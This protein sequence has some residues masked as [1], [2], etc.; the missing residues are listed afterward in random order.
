MSNFDK[1]K[2]RLADILDSPAPSP[3][4]KARIKDARRVRRIE[5]KVREATEA[6]KDVRSEAHAAQLARDQA[7][8]AASVDAVKDAA[9]K[10]RKHACAARKLAKAARKRASKAINRVDK[11]NDARM[12]QNAG[13]VVARALENAETATQDSRRA[14]RVAKRAKGI[15]ASAEAWNSQTQ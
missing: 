9:R 12:R 7:G 10:T 5:A 8:C 14:R 1:D 3:K 11:I 2:K 4:K 15:A 6:A 13:I